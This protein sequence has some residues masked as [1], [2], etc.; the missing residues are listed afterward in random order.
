MEEPR[1]E[2]LERLLASGVDPYPARSELLSGRLSSSKMHE[3]YDGLSPAQE[4]PDTVRF[5]G[6]MMTRRDMGK[7]C[8]AHLQD[9]EGRIQIYVRKDVLG[10]AAF[11]SFTKD[12]DLGDWLAVEGLAF[13]TKTGEV[14]VRAQKIELLSKALKPLQE[15]FHGLS[16]LDI[17]FSSFLI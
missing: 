7:A 5:A 17:F 12:L 9:G 4:S 3:R 6:R 1:K 13:K 11:D 8:F 2:K 14:S 16:K 15:K 10:D